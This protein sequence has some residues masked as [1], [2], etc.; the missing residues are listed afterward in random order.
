[1]PTETEEFRKCLH[2]TIKGIAEAAANAVRAHIAKHEEDRRGG[3]ITYESWLDT[4]TAFVDENECV[5]CGQP[6]LDSSLVDSYAE[7][8]SDAYKTLAEDAKAKRDTFGRYERGEYRSSAEDIA[9]QN[10]TLYAYW[11]EAGQVDTPE[12]EGVE[13]AVKGMEA[14]ARLLD[15]V[16]VEKQG[17][18]TE[19]AAGPDV[20]AAIT[21]WDEGR[22]EIVRLNG[23]IKGHVAEVKALKESVDET[24]LPRL[25]R[26]LKTSR[27]AKRRHEEDTR[28]VIEK[29]EGHEAKKRRIAEEK[30]KEKKQLNKHGRVITETL[31]K[32][33]NAY[34]GRLNAG[35]KIDYREPNYQGTEPAASYQILINEAC[36]SG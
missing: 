9:E 21:A 6:L 30:A 34:L 4:G 12:L 18:L 16:F 5:F 33:I 10:E 15:A 14:A 19:A 23:V 2:S 1:M 32:T 11:K 8:F 20:E 13:A 36:L 22:K 31:G 27:A 17:N 28:A 26:E 24:E 3:A 7:F 25:E 35:L 29:L